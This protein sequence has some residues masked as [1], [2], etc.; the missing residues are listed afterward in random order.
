MSNIDSGI[1]DPG[2]GTPP[3]DVIIPEEE[4]GTDDVGSD[5][6]R[7]PSNDVRPVEPDPEE[8]DRPVPSDIQHT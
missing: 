6:I 4:P 2:K 7:E 8:G 3:P 1:I 5:E